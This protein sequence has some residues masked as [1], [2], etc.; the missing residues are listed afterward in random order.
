MN[1]TQKLNSSQIL[2]DVISLCHVIINSCE[3]DQLDKVIYQAGKL[4]SWLDQIDEKEIRKFGKK[5]T[6]EMVD[7]LQLIHQANW[8][9]ISKGLSM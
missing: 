2:K 8:A 9:V 3:R 5:E 1:T 7:I 6:V 4:S